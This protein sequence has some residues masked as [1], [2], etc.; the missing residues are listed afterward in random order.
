M[1]VLYLLKLSMIYIFR[2]SLLFKSIITLRIT[3][4]SNTLKLPQFTKDQLTHPKLFIR[5]SKSL[6]YLLWNEF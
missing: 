5:T 1:Y 2:C 4:K 6:L 3:S